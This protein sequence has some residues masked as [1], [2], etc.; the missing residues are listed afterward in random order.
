MERKGLL[1]ERN[2]VFAFCVLCIMMF[3]ALF[4]FSLLLSWVNVEFWNEFVYLRVDSVLKNL[5]WMAAALLLFFLLGAGYQRFGQKWKMDYLAIGVSL[6]CMLVGFWWLKTSNTSPQGDQACITNFALDFEMGDVSGLA[7][8]EYLG[9]Y[10]QQLGLITLV[11]ILYKVTGITDYRCF[12][13][14]SVLMVPILVFSGYQVTKKITQDNGRAE[15]FYL[16][17]TVCCVPM[18][19]YVPFV[20]GEICSTTA[21]VLEAWVLLSCLERFRW[22]KLILLAAIAGFAVQTRKNTLVPMIGFLIVLLVKLIQKPALRLWAMGGAIVLGILLFQTVISLMY[23]PFTPRDSKPLPALLHITMGT[24]DQ[25]EGAPGWYDASNVGLFQEMNY[26]TE[27]AK[28]AAAEELKK[29]AAKCVEHPGYAM[30]FYTE[31]MNIQWNAPMYQCIVANNHFAGEWTAVV[32]SFYEGRAGAFLE[33]FMNIYQLLLYGGVLF[34]LAAKRREWNRVEKYVLLIG[35][36]GGFLFSLL[37]EAKP[38]YV[39]PSMLLMIPYAAIGVEC[40]LAKAA[41]LLRQTFCGKKL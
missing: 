4:G 30:D 24:H 3:T 15:L 41:Q 36:Y 35:V 14:F 37:W 22:Q 27:A 38:R 39:F 25:I 28:D 10:R 23:A 20:Y 33:K 18:Y 17:F 26:D 6:I 1:R 21:V 5:F 12:Q 2:L 16:L 34:L 40:F 13:Y 32:E 7:K 29:F 31:K 9:I 11:R 19:G 8:G